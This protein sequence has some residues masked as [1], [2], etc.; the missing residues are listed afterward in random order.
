MVSVFV[1]SVVYRG[2]EI[3]LAQTKDDKIGICCFSA[4]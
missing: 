3:R 4:N 2:F 1:S